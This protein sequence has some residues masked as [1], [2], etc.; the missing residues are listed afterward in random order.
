MSRMKRRRAK[1]RNSKDMSIPSS[2]FGLIGRSIP[3]RPNKLGI[4]LSK[5]IRDVDIVN[6]FTEKTPV[7]MIFFYKGVPFDRC[8]V[9]DVREQEIIKL[10]EK[11]PGWNSWT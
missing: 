6:F 1:K 4:A 8:D 5:A 11:E 2:S 9:K 7:R 3:T 10:L